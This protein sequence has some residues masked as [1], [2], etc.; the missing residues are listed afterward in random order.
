VTVLG[1]DSL[2]TPLA[3]GDIVRVV[4]GG[5]GGWGD[6]LERDPRLVREDVVDEYVSIDGARRDYGVV[7]DPATLDLDTAATAAERARR[8]SPT[9]VP[10]RIMTGDP[11]PAEAGAGG[12]TIASGA[13][14]ASQGGR[15]P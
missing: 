6:P 10:G 5:G 3:P 13:R 9:A 15:R 12:R 7:L 8:G 11:V 4:R 2:E 14:P 1:G